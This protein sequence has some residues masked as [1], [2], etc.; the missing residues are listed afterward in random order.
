MAA[1]H[2]LLCRLLLGFELHY[3]YI[4]FDKEH[5]CDANVIQRASDKYVKQGDSTADADGLFLRH[6][7]PFPPQFW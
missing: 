6:R 3:I 7:C 5:S 1:L 4:Y 2:V